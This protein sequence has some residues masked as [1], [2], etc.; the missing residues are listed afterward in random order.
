MVILTSRDERSDQKDPSTQG[1]F[2]HPQGE[3]ASKVRGVY[4]EQKTNETVLREGVGNPDDSDREDWGILGN[5]REDQLVIKESP[6]P[7]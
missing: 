3:E 7:R 5:I 1:P 4:R 2:L 6:S